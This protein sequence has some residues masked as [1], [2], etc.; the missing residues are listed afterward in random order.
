MHYVTF[1]I[2]GRYGH[3]KKPETNNNPG[4]YSFMHKTALIGF[5]GAVLGISREAM[6]PLFPILCDGLKMAITIN[7]EVIKEVHGFT[8]HKTVKANFFKQGRGYR[9]FVRNPDYTITVALAD[10]KNKELF[11]KFTEMLKRGET[12]Y[13]VYFGNSNCPAEF[14]FIE[15]GKFKGPFSG[16]FETKGIISSEHHDIDVESNLDITV[17]RIPTFQ[18]D[19]FYN[20]P[21]R[22]V[23]V[24]FSLS[25][26]KVSGEYYK[27]ENGDCLWIM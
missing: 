21:N 2:W 15:E 8:T 27:K 26:M 6:K 20:P 22:F 25:S 11:I 1:H 14:K 9:E 17:E 4:S 18:N 24:L 16:T 13:P 10:E 19:N 23:S 12:G 3:F 7:K 5:I